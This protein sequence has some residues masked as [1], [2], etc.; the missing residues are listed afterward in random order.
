M[1]K[2]EDDEVLLT[3]VM[4]EFTEHMGKAVGSMFGRDNLEF[5]D[6]GSFKMCAVF[7]CGCA[8]KIGIQ[9]KGLAGEIAN[10]LDFPDLTCFPRLL[11]YDGAG[12]GSCVV[13][14]V[15]PRFGDPECEKFYG[16]PRYKVVALLSGEQPENDAD[17]KFLSNL[18]DAKGPEWDSMRDLDTFFRKYRPLYDISYNNW[19]LA[20]R[21]GHDVPVVLDYDL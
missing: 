7:K 3:G 1:N 16:V 17:G 21:N 2:L 13:E 20:K 15:N 8:L 14:A 11:G 6:C 10:S 5:V 4:L 18:R 9:D 19:G 12:K